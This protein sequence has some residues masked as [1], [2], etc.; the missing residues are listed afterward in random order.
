MSSADPHF[1]H[2]GIFGD[3]AAHDPGDIRAEV[4]PPCDEAGLIV[5][6]REEV[7][8]PSGCKRADQT[9]GITRRGQVSVPKLRVRESHVEILFG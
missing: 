9:E 1:E 7:L 5:E 3:E 2:P 6:Q 8:S 4:A